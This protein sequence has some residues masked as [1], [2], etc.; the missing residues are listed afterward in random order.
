MHADLDKINEWQIH[1]R[2]GN[3]MHLEKTNPIITMT[4]NTL[5]VVDLE[6]DLR[7]IISADLRRLQQ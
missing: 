1:L 4:E 7:I 2:T 6:K 5:K 3:V